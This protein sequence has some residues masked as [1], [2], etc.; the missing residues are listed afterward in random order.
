V[1]QGEG[2]IYIFELR[3]NPGLKANVIS[4]YKSRFQSEGFFRPRIAENVTISGKLKEHTVDIYFEFFQMNNLERTVIKV[5]E[6]TE[7]TEN[8]MWEFANVLKDLHFWAKGV[9]YYDDRVS[10]GAK[11]VA[12]LTNIDLKKF[13]LLDEVSKSASSYLKVML[14][15]EEIIGDP[16]WT[17]METEQDSGKN[18]GNYVMVNDYSILLFLSKKQAIN[19][20][21]KMEES[22]KVFG[23]SQNHLKVLVSLREKEK[24]PDFSIAFP[25]FEQLQEGSVACYPIP[26]KNL[27][28]IYLRGDN[29]E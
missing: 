19:Y 1:L 25:E 24:F 18:T 22:A 4:M 5:I 8:D 29:N 28:K 14:P 20:C 11:K 26:H 6:G 15:D 10:S 27:K 3:K 7:V 2:G 16:F 21:S 17:V 23:V 13:D 9:I 12:E